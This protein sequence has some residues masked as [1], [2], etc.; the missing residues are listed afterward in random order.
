ML[1][2]RRTSGEP[3]CLN[4]AADTVETSRYRNYKLAPCV[5]HSTTAAQSQ[6]CHRQVNDHHDIGDGDLVDPD[7]GGLRN[8]RGHHGGRAHLTIWSGFVIG[9]P[10]Y[11]E[12]KNSSLSGC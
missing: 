9:R 11:P 10:L 5:K 8:T 3:W 2:I 6:R 7:P 1:G 12:P 4:G